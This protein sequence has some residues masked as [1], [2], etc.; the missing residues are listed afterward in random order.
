MA[1]PALRALLD[2]R[3]A[4]DGILIPLPI[5]EILQSLELT[6]PDPGGDD[7]AS[8]ASI[9]RRLTLEEF[10]SFSLEP[11]VDPV[12]LQ[13]SITSA[14]HPT[15]G[16]RIDVLPGDR[17]V[18]PSELKP[19]R[20]IP[21]GDQT[22]LV[23]DGTGP[24]RVTGALA[25]RIEG[26]T[27]GS[28]TLRLIGP[29]S[30]DAV[31]TLATQPKALLFGD[32]GF[33][34]ELPGG[35]VIDDSSAA[36]PPPSP[37]SSGPSAAP[38]W[39]GVALRGARLFLPSHTP[40]VG[41]VPLEVAFE[42]G[43]PAGLDGHADLT[44]PAQDDR[45]EMK[46]TIDW[47]DPAATSL[48]ECLPTAIEIGVDFPV[49]GGSTSVAGQPVTLL[50]ANPLRMRARFTRDVRRQPPG[51]VFDLAVEGGG[52]DGLIAVSA[53]P[54]QV[55]PKI[56]VTASALAVAFMADADQ[57]P[58]PSG[59]GTGSTLAAL[60]AAASALS[61]VVTNSGKTVLHGIEIEGDIASAEQ[62]LRM[63]VDYS[64][65]LAVSKIEM[66]PLKIRM[67]D[68]LPMRV[69]YRNVALEIDLA[70]SGLDRFHLSYDRAEFGVDDPGKWIIEG[71]G[72]IFDVVGTRSGHGSVWY[73]VDLR[74]A[75]DLGPIKVSGATI[76]ATTD[77]GTPSVS[78]RG[79]D[80][81]VD[82]PGIVRGSGRSSISH[83]GVD[84]ALAAEIIPLQIGAMAFASYE[85]AGDYN[86]IL[87]G[88]GVDLPG[89]IPLAATGLGI[90][91]IL[92]VFGMNGTFSQPPAGA[93]PVEELLKWKPWDPGAVVPARNSTVVGFG[94]V[95]GTLP[96]LGFT[97]STKAL[98]L[99]AVPDLAVRMMLDG[100]ILAERPKLTDL[101]TPP[102]VGFTLLG[103]LAA[104]SSGL[105]I[106][107]RGRFDIP[108]LLEIVV[109]F[110]ARFPTSGNDWYVHLGTDGFEGRGPGPIEVKV[111]P[112]ILD[113]GASAYLM[114]R[115]AG[116]PNFAGLGR[117]L[118]GF[119]I[120][121]GF[122]W[123]TSTGFAIVRLDLSASAAVGLG[124]NPLMFIGHGG[125]RGSLHLGPVSIGVSAEV[126]LQL[127]PTNDDKWAHFEVCGE[128]DLFFFSISGCIDLS[129]GSLK[130]TVPD[131]SSW[132][133]DRVTLTDRSYG[134]A[135]DAS[136]DPNVAP[137]V[138]PDCI[139][140]LSFTTGPANGLTGG[141]FQSKLFGFAPG[142]W[143]HETGGDGSYGSTDLHYT[144][145]IAEL[146]LTE[147]DP[148]TGV[149]TPMPDGLEAAWQFPKH[150]STSG[151]KSLPGA[152]ELAL[153]SWKPYHWMQTLPDGGQGLPSDP[154]PPFIDHCNRRWEA[155]PNWALGIEATRGSTG[156]PW[157]MPSEPVGLFLF[158]SRF[159]VLV[160]ARWGTVDLDEQSVYEI[161]VPAGISLGGPEM[162][163]E[164][165]RAFERDFNGVFSL[166]R[167]TGIS[168]DADDPRESWL[169]E[170][171]LEAD[172]I[173]DQTLHGLRFV[174]LV[175]QT[176]GRHHIDGMKVITVAPDGTAA[177]HWPDDQ[178]SLSNNWIALLYSAPTEW[179]RIQVRYDGRL[180]VQ[181]AG[182]LAWTSQALHDVGLA[183]HASGFY[184]DSLAAIAS[185]PPG[186]HQNLLE[187]GKTYRL[188]VRQKATGR[189]PTGPPAEFFNPPLPNP[190]KSYFF[191]TAAKPSIDVILPVGPLALFERKAIYLT[192]DSFDPTY[193]E[194]YLLGYT[195]LDK[196]GAWFFE[197]PV[198]VHFAVEYIGQLAKQYDRDVE[199]LCR[200][201][202]TPPEEPD[203]GVI[204][205][206]N[207]LIALTAIHLAS[208]VEKRLSS[209]S[210][211]GGCRLP[212][213]GSTILGKP[214]LEPGGTY[215]LA[216][217]FPKPG[218][219]S[220][221]GALPGVIFTTSQWGTPR[222]LLAALGFGDVPG[223][224]GGDVEVRV[225]PTL[226]T[227]NITSDGSVEDALRLVG[228]ERW[229][230]P[231]MPRTTHLWSRIGSDG[232]KLYGVLLE[233]P[234][235]LHRPSLSTL[236]GDIS[237]LTIGDLRAAGG[238]FDIVRRNSSGTRHLYLASTP[239]VPLDALVLEGREQGVSLVGP[240]IPAVPFALRNAV[241][242]MPGFQEDL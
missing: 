44:I 205:T 175:D 223:R 2:S 210:R 178:I 236:E 124:T 77:G 234:E 16:F 61:A 87:L 158:A 64:V 41:G 144:F 163:V 196:T 168:F 106:G 156:D 18:L 152:R 213:S 42:L 225:E 48:A 8:T 50:G 20:V 105:T 146:N 166:P 185:A 208:P 183:D 69:R 182:V 114:V 194:R 32:S 92:G 6:G 40:L 169:Q 28:A 80:A 203:T 53:E 58:A 125:L 186:A 204:F 233:S 142:K 174:L 11:G 235:P 109:P 76:R 99:L 224:A 117:D 1:G 217:S 63:K 230:M 34:L 201:T 19:A 4:T 140:I 193:L 122:G 31:V 24:I 5:E 159:E 180:P 12:D 131:P 237:R 82:L 102:A 145:E 55:G 110:G 89:P 60:F 85:D 81:R 83:Q 7:F 73:E 130:E 128:V 78:L 176:A 231:L 212:P 22:A 108:R 188:D 47:H 190:P 148:K 37:G 177:A 23:P 3:G 179:K 49:E 143:N 66:G 164:P 135:R 138:W 84:L 170:V 120:G 160:S 229:S 45:P 13:V 127:G 141:P 79:L 165:F 51:M 15:P 14:P 216:V 209:G 181:F 112:D 126:D 25:I 35:L 10:A 70:A 121:F 104:D 59:D 33:G 74:F 94:A 103:M 98:L 198:A 93:D 96:D 162:L 200:R 218:V 206:I 202:D 36:G 91:G 118:E 9:S 137:T 115:G 38:V 214:P 150:G 149:E 72:S 29:G 184:S 134:D 153:L 172:F 242:S 88:V 107:M 17:L 133:L 132:P 157:A 62:V 191:K 215:E 113:L 26:R 192:R 195:P 39:R 86:K 207:H 167:F 27:D 189:R 97:F 187:P 221:G 57:H 46:V 154:I 123:Q 161:P 139:P 90:Y 151:N 171:P 228:L 21:A 111:L 116:I 136:T 100:R 54:G 226:A 232:W 220:S 119:A 219:P 239:F 222:H 241:T 197:D 211:G 75:V 52:A 199:L 147:I 240:A 67:D 65:Q 30:P 129:I 71:P 95:V 43:S 155:L 227:G 68:R 101:G 173:F 238:V 56:V